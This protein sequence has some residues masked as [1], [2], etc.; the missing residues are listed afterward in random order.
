M[1]FYC[2][3]FYLAAAVRF[4]V[5]ADTHPGALQERLQLVFVKGFFS[6]LMDVDV[7]I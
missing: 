2:V 1:F 7:F 5:N 4:L 6:I 3:R